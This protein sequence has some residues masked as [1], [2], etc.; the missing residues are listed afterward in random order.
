MYL[1][2]FVYFFL[3]RYR[4]KFQNFLKY[5][6]SICQDYQGVQ[7]KQLQNNNILSENFITLL[8]FVKIFL[9][10]KILTFISYS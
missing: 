4:K 6:L 1:I 7:N 2:V 3:K 9:N 5:A 8:Q 10:N